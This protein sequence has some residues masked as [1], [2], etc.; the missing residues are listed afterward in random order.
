MGET[1]KRSA[2]AWLRYNLDD[3]VL[4][5]ISRVGF[6]KIARGMVVKVLNVVLG[7][8]GE[9]A[10]GVTVR[11]V[12]VEEIARAKFLLTANVSATSWTIRIDSG[13]EGFVGGNEAGLR[14]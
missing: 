12:L 14:A 4:F 11:N 1:S 6:N 13:R 2:N 7:V 5:G 3:D 8:Q 10:V 9:R